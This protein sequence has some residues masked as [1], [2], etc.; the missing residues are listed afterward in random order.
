[1]EIF[2]QNIPVELEFSSEPEKHS[3]KWEIIAIDE[4]QLY[5]LPL[6]KRPVKIIILGVSYSDKGVLQ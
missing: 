1:M 4:L 5:Y 6:I 2:Y 3:F